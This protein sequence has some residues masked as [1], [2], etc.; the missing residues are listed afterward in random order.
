LWGPPSNRV[1]MDQDRHKPTRR[2]NKISK[3][4]HKYGKSR[5][6]IARQHFSMVLLWRQLHRDFLRFATWTR[7][8]RRRGNFY[9]VVQ[10]QP[11]LLCALSTADQE[12]QLSKKDRVDRGPHNISGS[13]IIN[14]QVVQKQM[15]AGLH[16]CL[17]DSVEIANHQLGDRHRRRDVQLIFQDITCN[18][19][20]RLFC[21]HSADL[22]N[23]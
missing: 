17:E 6:L 23:S 1:Q 9:Q 20:S 14:I 3:M 13:T 8:S 7:P 22:L 2:N 4:L 18:A 21:A 5:I 12:P 19:A 16:S 11:P 10:G 15:G